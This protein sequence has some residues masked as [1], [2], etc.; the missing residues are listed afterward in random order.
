MSADDALRYLEQEEE[1]AAREVSEVRLVFDV[2][3]SLLTLITDRVC[4]V[5]IQ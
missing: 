1:N 5:R 2:L 4:F 3:T